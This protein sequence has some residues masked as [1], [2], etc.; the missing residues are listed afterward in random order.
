MQNVDPE[1]GNA[2]ER[3]RVHGTSLHRNPVLPT[4]FHYEPKR[5]E[6]HRPL[7]KKGGFTLLARWCFSIIEGEK[8]VP[9]SRCQLHG[10]IEQ[11]NET[12]WDLHFQAVFN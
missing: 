6:K 3:H 2:S 7:K 12:R 5:S 1:E 9:G 8:N 11:C 10:S 4:Q